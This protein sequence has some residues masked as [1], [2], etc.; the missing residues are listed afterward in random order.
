MVIERC[1]LKNVDF[2]VVYFKVVPG[3]P[4]EKVREITNYAMKA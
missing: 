3:Y 1:I 2:V 4:L